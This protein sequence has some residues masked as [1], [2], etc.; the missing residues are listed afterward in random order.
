MRCTIAALMAP[1]DNV[2]AT[3]RPSIAG[4]RAGADGLALRWMESSRVAAVAGVTGAA[5]TLARAGRPGNTIAWIVI[6]TTPSPMAQIVNAL[7]QPRA[8]W[9]AAMV[10]WKIVDANPA[11]RVRVVIAQ[12]ARR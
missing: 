9:R 1:I 2:N 11:T 5:W 4:S 7:R 10:G 3:V 6:V 12:V 8:S